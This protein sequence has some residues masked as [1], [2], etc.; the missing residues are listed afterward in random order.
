VIDKRHVWKRQPRDE[1]KRRKCVPAGDSQTATG[2]LIARQKMHSRD[3]FSA[4]RCHVP[5]HAAAH[6]TLA[7]QAWGHWT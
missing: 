6:V 2:G 4:G 5:L 1:R 7:I 3:L